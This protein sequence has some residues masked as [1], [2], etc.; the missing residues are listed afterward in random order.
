MLKNIY[1]GYA[2][3]LR[4]ESSDGAEF[5]TIGKMDICRIARLL[6]HKHNLQSKVKTAKTNRKRKSFRKA[7]LRMNKKI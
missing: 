4:E 5:I 7:F 3:D 1:T 6:H 2:M